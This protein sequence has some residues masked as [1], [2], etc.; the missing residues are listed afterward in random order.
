MNDGNNN[1]T[2]T[3]FSPK[4]S[5]KSVRTQLYE[6]HRASPSTQYPFTSDSSL[7][8]I[9]RPPDLQ[10]N[11]EENNTTLPSTPSTFYSFHPTNSTAHWTNRCCDISHPIGQLQ[12]PESPKNLPSNE[13]KVCQGHGGHQPLYQR[14]LV[15]HPTHFYRHCHH[16]RGLAYWARRLGFS[17]LKPL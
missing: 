13:I 15:R 14:Q 3:Q 2:S 16:H 17:R 10:I 7:R 6:S 12:Q 4:S 9:S 5:E 8:S 1:S 11:P